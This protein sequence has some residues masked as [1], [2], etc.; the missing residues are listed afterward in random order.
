LDQIS[1]RFPTGEKV[2]YAGP[3]S[4][5]GGE[6]AVWLSTDVASANWHATA[7]LLAKLAGDA[8]FVDMGS[9]TTD[10]IAVRNAA[11]TNDGY[12]DARWLLTGE[13][14]YI[15]FTRTFL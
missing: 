10:I 2:V 12:T 15:G 5:V 3:S 8:L 11:V 13:F 1:T 7:S 9:T 4:F 14:G 6:Q